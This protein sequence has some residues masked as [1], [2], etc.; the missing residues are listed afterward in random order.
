EALQELY[1]LFAQYMSLYRII[2]SQHLDLSNESTR[3]ELLKEIAAAEGRVDATILRVASEFTQDNSE[4]LSAYL[5][6]LRQSVQIWRENVREGRE[7]PFYG[8]GQADYARFKGAFV[9]TCTYLASQIYAR[10]E[11]TAVVVDQAASVLADVFDN[12][13]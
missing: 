4:P 5:A 10:V 13:H 7:L 12:R 1:S 6:D 9:R 3:R 8:S 2:N 11:P